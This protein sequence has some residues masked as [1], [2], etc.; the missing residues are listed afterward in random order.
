MLNTNEEQ[1]DRHAEK[2]DQNNTEIFNR[3]KGPSN[4]FDTG[5]MLATEESVKNF[6]SFRKT[7]QQNTNSIKQEEDRRRKRR[8]REHR[9]ERR[10]D[11]R[12]RDGQSDRRDDR[13]DD[14]RGDRRD[15]RD[16]HHSSSRRDDRDRHRDDRD[17]HRDDRDRHRDDRHRDSERSDNRQNESGYQE[18][19]ENN[20][21]DD[22]GTSQR[23]KQIETQDYNSIRIENQPASS[24]EKKKR[25]TK[26]ASKKEE[27]LQMDQIKENLKAKRIP[28]Y[29]PRDVFAE[30]AE[31]RKQE[32]E[33]KKKMKIEE[34]DKQIEKAKESSHSSMV[35]KYVLVTF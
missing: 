20:N 1:L 21:P 27:K 22:Y 6:L 19:F 9:D 12:S 17:R 25:N 29:I 2:V 30:D 14:R 11:H 28:G 3:R 24:T 34:E 33:R 18:V 10:K 26:K 5:K 23:K 4:R 8:H 13:R 15:D 16:R 35:D 31:M 32:E 7:Q